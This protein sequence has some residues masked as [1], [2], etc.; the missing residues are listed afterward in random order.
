MHE[1]SRTIQ[2][3]AGRWIN[4]YGPGPAKGL[5]LPLEPGVSYATAGDAVAAAKIRSQMA[6]PHGHD[7][8]KPVSYDQGGYVPKG[9]KASLAGG[10]YV[11]RASVVPKHRKLLETINA[12]GR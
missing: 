11:V 6:V 5:T 1:Q 10:E 9:L 2:N 4:V 8:E 12:K 7:E 3:R